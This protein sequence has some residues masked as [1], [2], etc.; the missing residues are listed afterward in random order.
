MNLMGI[1]G[2]LGLFMVG[3]AY[4]MVANQGAAGLI[5]RNG[6]MGIRTKKTQSSDAAWDA[7]HYAA[8]PLVRTLGFVS[9]V[10]GAALVFSGVV[11]RQED[12]P[13]ITVLL[14]ALGYGSVL[15]SNIPLVIK[16]NA[17]VVS[18]HETQD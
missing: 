11:W 7:A 18:A 16:A 14:F 15:L 5:T 4:L 17:A 1:L 2:G 6:A 9:L 13:G 3:G 8:A 12:P 10:F